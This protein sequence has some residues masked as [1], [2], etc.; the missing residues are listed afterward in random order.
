LGFGVFRE[1]WFPS[2]WLPG[3]GSTMPSEPRPC[4]YG[5]PDCFSTLVAGA[6]DVPEQAARD[7]PVST[8][9]PAPVADIARQAGPMTPA[10]DEQ[11]AGGRADL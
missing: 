3:L 4:P 9:G 7:L 1:G 11:A 10:A 8:G 2:V 6:S 5:D